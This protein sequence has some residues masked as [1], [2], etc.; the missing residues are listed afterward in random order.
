MEPQF[1]L[2]KDREQ[3]FIVDLSYISH[4]YV[5]TQSSIENLFAKQ[6]RAKGSLITLLFFVD[7]QNLATIQRLIFLTEMNGLKSFLYKVFYFKEF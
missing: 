7:K 6:K 2:L 3:T 4:W 5:L 1:P